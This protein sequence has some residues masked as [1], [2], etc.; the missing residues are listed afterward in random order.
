M[1]FAI[2]TDDRHGIVHQSANFALGSRPAKNRADPGRAAHARPPTGGW[3][4]SVGMWRGTSLVSLSEWRHRAT[5][6]RDHYVKIVREGILFPFGHRAAV[7]KISER[8]VEGLNADGSDPVAALRR[9]FYIIIR[10]LRA[11]LCVDGL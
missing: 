5:E 11:H 2:D 3:L 7:V 9:R 6:G 1:T 10:E 4:R 8:K